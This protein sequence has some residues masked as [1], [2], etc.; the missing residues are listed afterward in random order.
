MNL[1]VNFNNQSDFYYKKIISN[2]FDNI[3]FEDDFERI[4]EFNNEKHLFIIGL[5]RSGSSLVE[6]LISHN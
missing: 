4:D 2:Q 3:K 5:P 1:N 6:T